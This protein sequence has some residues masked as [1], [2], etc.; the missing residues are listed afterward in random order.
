VITFLQHF[1]PY[2]LGVPFTICTDHGALSWIHKFKEPQRQIAW[3]VQQLEEYEFKIIHRLGAQ[4]KNVDATS[5]IP[6]KQC[7]MVPADETVAL[8]A[9]AILNLA[10]LCEYSKNCVI[11]N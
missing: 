9:V 10:S 2:L 8:A 3:W 1:H 7:G 6:C 4:H 5:C 11:L